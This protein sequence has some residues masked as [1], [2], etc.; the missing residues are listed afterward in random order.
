[1]H[2]LHKATWSLV[3]ISGKTLA[4][5]VKRS[6]SPNQQDTCAISCLLSR[7]Q[8]LDNYQLHVSGSQSTNINMDWK[9]ASQKSLNHMLQA[10]YPLIADFGLGEIHEYGEEWTTVWKDVLRESKEDKRR[11]GKEADEGWW[12]EENPY[13]K[14][15]DKVLEWWVGSVWGKGRSMR[16]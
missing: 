5:P 2:F 8:I 6:A 9:M 11:H 13:D 7:G 14:S 1:M 15:G 3:A 4:A 12:E 16:S 10:W